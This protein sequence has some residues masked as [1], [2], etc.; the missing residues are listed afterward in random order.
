MSRFVPSAA[1]CRRTSLGSV[2]RPPSSPFSSAGHQAGSTYPKMIYY[3]CVC[4]QAT[5][6]SAYTVDSHVIF[7]LKDF[8]TI[9][10]SKFNY[11]L[12]LPLRRKASNLPCLRSQNDSDFEFSLHFGLTQ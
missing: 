2:R 5:G 12:P 9:S 3:N 11:L 10:P 1:L 7:L 6:L 8:W 4:R